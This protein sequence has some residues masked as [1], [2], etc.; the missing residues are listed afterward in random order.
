MLGALGGPR[1][2]HALAN[3]GLLAHPA[4]QA[5]PVWLFDARC[6]RLSLLVA[7]EEPA[8]CRLAGRV[9]DLVSLI[10]WGET[11][12]GVTTTG[13]RYPLANEPLLLGQT[14]GVSNVR[15]APEATVTLQAG[16]LL[17]I[18]TPVTVGA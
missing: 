18:E 5:D 14:R 1:T 17:V 11:A 6:A 15:T 10:P 8:T 4:L 7:G 12:I 16:R 2:D 9:R 13:L 3:I